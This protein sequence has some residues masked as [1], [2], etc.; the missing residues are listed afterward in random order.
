[1][2]L[3]LVEQANELLRKLPCY[4]REME[5]CL[6]QGQWALTPE[7]QEKRSEAIIHIQIFRPRVGDDIHEFIKKYYRYARE[8]N[9]EVEVVVG[10]VKIRIRPDDT[11]TE[12]DLI[13]T[14]H[15][16]LDRKMDEYWNSPEGIKEKTKQ[17]KEEVLRRRN[18][19]S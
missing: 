19:T 17:A 6:T 7:G 2:S 4:Y 3:N 15:H 16:E 10:G 18:K 8:R 12:E 11:A 9:E 1:M 13:G 14:Y 5:N